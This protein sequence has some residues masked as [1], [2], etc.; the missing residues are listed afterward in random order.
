M[1]VHMNKVCAQL[2]T[3]NDTFG[4]KCI[5]VYVFL[6]WVCVVFA[7][8]DDDI[9]IIG[10]VTVVEKVF[11]VL[12]VLGVTVETIVLAFVAS[13]ANEGAVFVVVVSIVVMEAES[14]MRSV[15]SVLA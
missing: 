15:L 9:S 3:M 2:I 13:V 7:S 14:V 5:N 1:C 4:H 12:A 11:V 6:L 8:V 10:I